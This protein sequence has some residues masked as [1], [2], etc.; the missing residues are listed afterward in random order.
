[1][2]EPHVYTP[3]VRAS[4]AS[5]VVKLDRIGLRTVREVEARI[6]AGLMQALA[7]LEARE[8]NRVVN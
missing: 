1:M 7:R 2:I 5:R 3:S 4:T 6:A 8:H